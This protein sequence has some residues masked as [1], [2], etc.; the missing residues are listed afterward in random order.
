MSANHDYITNLAILQVINIATCSVL[1]SEIDST[2]SPD[3][4]L[5]IIGNSYDSPVLRNNYYYSMTTDDHV[6]FLAIPVG[7]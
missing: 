5:E 7:K 2:I 1:L 6:E 4:A 3:E